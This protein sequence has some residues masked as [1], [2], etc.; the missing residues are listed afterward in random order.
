MNE[1]SE[2][3][4]KR[5]FPIDTI[6]NTE[7]GNLTVINHIPDH[8]GMGYIVLFKTQKGNEIS[9]HPYFIGSRVY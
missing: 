1:Y 9:I 2:I 5:Q 6:W 4:V 3:Q 7:W 8:D